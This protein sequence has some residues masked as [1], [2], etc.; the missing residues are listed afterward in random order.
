MSKLRFAIVGC[1][2]IHGTH[3]EAIQALE[4]DAILVA[5]CDIVE[6][7]ANT[8]AQKLG[9]RAFT[10]LDA[11]LAWGEFDVLN[12][13]T[14]SGLHA[15]CGIKGANAGKHVISEKPIEVSLEAAD[16]L[17]A[18]CKANNVKLE[19][20]SQHRFSSGIRQ[21]KQWL[22]AGRLGKLIYGESVTK[23]YR[24]QAYY[25]SGGWRGTWALDGGGALMN[26]G[27]HYVDML[28]WIM[29]PVKSVSAT[30]GT[31]AHE[32]IEVEDIVSASI[33]FENGAVGT[34]TASTA[35]FPGYKQSLEIYGT[36]GT[37]LIDNSKVWHAQFATGDEEQSMFGVKAAE[38]VVKNG[39]FT[40]TGATAAEMGPHGAGDPTA[41]A[42]GGHVAQLKDLIDAV[43]ED[44]ETFMNGAEARAALEVIVGVYTSAKNNGKRIDFPL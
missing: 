7:R 43:R 24:T 15:E 9:V 6:E 28:R 5:V 14:P 10:D 21:L 2:V 31:I 33:A 17:I 18:A 20:I 16:A 39:V 11:M 41:I 38:P 4:S 8:T 22:D 1:G 37:V 13:C 25:D 27:V 23:W 29:G 44:R 34:L 26:Q 30:M 42:L 12:V 36:H 19:V 32:R 35:M 40:E 3:I